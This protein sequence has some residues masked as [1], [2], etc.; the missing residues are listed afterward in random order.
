MKT[1]KT[2]FFKELSDEALRAEY[3]GYVELSYNNAAMVQ[4]GAVNIK[5]AAF[6]MERLMR[7][8]RIIEGV[9]RKRGIRL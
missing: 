8:R 2:P 6:Q 1:T 9:A 4:C 7:N 5:K 3:R